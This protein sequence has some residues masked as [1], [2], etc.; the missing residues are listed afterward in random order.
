MFS[1]N[2]Y[3]YHTPGGKCIQTEMSVEDFENTT[4]ILKDVGVDNLLSAMAAIQGLLAGEKG[5]SV[6]VPMDEYI[7]ALLDVIGNIGAQGSLTQFIA[8]VLHI[9]T[10][11]AAKIPMTVVGSVVQDFFILNRGWLPIIQSFLSTK[12]L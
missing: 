10:D 7:E 2:K 4:I 6:A 3:T 11:K 8:Q 1:R 9:D 5:K 12:I